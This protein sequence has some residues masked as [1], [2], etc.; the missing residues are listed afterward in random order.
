MLQFLQKPICFF[1]NLTTSNLKLKANTSIGNYKIALFVFI[2]ILFIQANFAQTNGDFRS[3]IVAGD[4]QS[5]GSW[6]TYNG[7]SWVAATSYPGQNAGAYE[8][9][10]LT[11]HTIYIRTD[12]TSSTMGDVI[13]NGR[14]NVGWTRNLQITLNTP[15]LYLNGGDLGFLHQKTELYLPTNSVI[16]IDNGGDI[17]GR[18]SNNTEIYIGGELTAVCRGGGSTVLTF[19]EVVAGGGTINSIITSPATSPYV[20]CGGQDINLL[21][22][23]GGA[24]TNVSYEW[25][26]TD[27]SSVDV[28]ISNS[29][30]TLANNTATT[31]ATSFTPATNGNYLVSLS[32]TDGNFTNIESKT[33]TISAGTAP[34]ITSTSPGSVTGTGTAILGATASAGT[35]N[36]YA[37]LTGGSSLGTGTSFT[38]PTISSTTTYYVD[39]TSGGCTSSPRIAIVATGYCASNGNSTNDEYIGRVQLN[40]IDNSSGVGTTST[41]YSDFTSISTDLTIGSIYSITITPTWTGSR[42]REGYNVW[43]DYNNDGDFTDSGENVYTQSRTNALS[44]SG[45]FSI[46]GSAVVGNT[47]MRVSMKY[48]A[49]STS[50]ESFGYGEVEDYTINIQTSAPQPEI[51][52]VGNGNDILDGDATPS[53]T[54]DT[55]FGTALVTSGSV[56]HTFTIQ[57]TGAVDLTLDNPSPYVVIAGDTS[58]FTLTS[59]PTTPIASSGSTTFTITFDPTS[60]GTKNATISIANNDSNENPYNFSITGQGTVPV[61]SNTVITLPYTQDFESGTNGWNTGGSDAE[62]V[63]NTTWSYSNNYS[64]QIRDN[65]GES[66]SFCSPVMSLNAYDKVDFKFFFSAYSME[67]NEDFFIEYSSD[68]GSTWTIIDTFKSGQVADKE[69]DFENTTLTIFY[70]KTSTIFKTDHTFPVATEARFRVRC[71]ASDDNDIIFIDDISIKGTT[72]ANPTNGPG[73]V[74]SDLDL[75]LKADKV[76]GTSVAADGSNLSKWVDNGKGNDAEVV[77][78]GQEPTY[79]NSTARNINF[80]PVVDFENDNTTASSDMTYLTSRDELKGTGGFNSNDMFVVIIPDPTITNSM[81]P[82]DTFTSKDPTGETYQEDVTGFGYGSFTQRL[83]GEYFTYC[84]GTSQE[85]PPSSGTYTGFGRGDAS[86]SNNYNQISIINVRHNSSNDNMELYLNANQVGTSTND[87]GDFATITNTRYWL[88]RSQY[89]NGSFDGRIAE[90]ITYSSTKS[91]GNLTQDRNRIQSYLGIKYG[92][93]LG[94][95]GTSQDY[96]DSDGSVIWDQSVNDGYNFDVAGIGRDDASELNQK[97]SKSV[98]DA[99]DG[100]GPTQGVLTMGLTDIYDTNSENISINSANNLGNKQ[101]L[102]WGNNGIDLNFATSTIDVNM[103][104]GISPALSTDVHFTGMQR[105]WKVVEN[106]GDIPKVKIGLRKDAVRNITPPG[107]YLMFISDNGVFTPTSDYRI[108]TES[109][110]NLYTEYDFDGT[111]YITFGYAPETVVERSIYFNGSADYIDMEDALDLSG[112]E[113]TISSWIK[114][115]SGSLNKSILSK[116]NVGYSE[117]YDF[118]INNSGKVEMSW[119]NSGAQ[120]ITSNTSIPENT[121]HQVAVIYNSGIAK[122]YID[123]VLDKTVSSLSNPSATTQSFFIAAAGKNAPEAFFKGNIDE[124]RIWDVALSENQ[125]RYIMNQEIVDN[126]N[127]TNGTVI[128]NTITKNEIEIIPYSNLKGY[129]PMSVYTYTNTNDMSGNLNQGALRNLNTVDRQT[130]P[131]PYKSQSN[132]SWNSAGTWLNNSVQSLPNSLSIVDGTTSIDWNIVETNHD[133]TIDTYS[134][135]GREVKVLG[136]MVNSNKIQVNGSTSAV[137]GNG[138]NVS[139][140]LKLDGTIDLEGESQ[141]IQTT[142]SDLVVGASGRLERDQQGEGNKYRY[143]DWS[144]PVSSTAV[145]STFKVVDVLKD[146][147]N[148]GVDINF[149]GGYDGNNATNPIQIANFWIYAFR[150]RL[151]DDYSQWEQVGSTTNLKAGEGFLMKGTGS[152]SDQNYVFKGVPNNGDITLSITGD[153]DYLVGNPYPSALDADQFL[154][155]NAGNIEGTLYFWE[156]YGGD[157]HNLKG[158]QAGYASYNFSGSVA[159]PHPITDLTAGPG[160][161]LPGRFIPIGQGFTIQGLG[162]GSKNV[163]FNNGQRAFQKEDVTNSIFMRTGRIKKKKSVTEVSAD[164]RPKF[165]IGFDV[166]GRGHRELLL[167]I[168]ERATE[169]I[170]WGFDGAVYDMLNDDMYWVIEDEKHVIQGTNNW[171]KSMEVPFGIVTE[172][173]GSFSIKIDRLENV[174][175]NTSLYIKDLLT[176]ETYDIT[177]NPFEVDLEAGE[178]NDRYALTFQPRLKTLE[179]IELFRGFN[180]FMDNKRSE[181]HV[182]KIVDTNLLEIELYNILG[183]NVARFKDKYTDRNLVLPLSVNTGVYIVKIMTSNGLISKKIIIE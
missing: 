58:E 104:S 129:Y 182:N 78:S 139:H 110:G 59:N 171:S 32:V 33:I 137:T 138:L 68:D 21:G 140:Y 80:N 183:Q 8:V 90:I 141:L 63:N 99:S 74:I 13:V 101:F 15:L 130:A 81:L 76:D 29:T 143:N 69:C 124:V 145:N 103:S 142:G 85:S 114:R 38:T 27:P 41:G 4:W 9:T 10:I 18:C 52:I 72:Y 95:N 28:A 156:H 87:S 122:L 79:R 30:G 150:N 177:N 61:C 161:K 146:G 172:E 37:N 173:G 39:A 11:G 121:W 16:Q 23:F 19:G 125:L 116:R 179:E 181:L 82:L 26:V 88:G 93:T 180:I 91:S 71:D 3:A 73:G 123:G 97:Q 89:W 113:F 128:P 152:P 158:Y 98:N 62:R 70:S 86:G 51:N 31:T 126:S 147:T 159:V 24:V 151:N 115:V 48:D 119:G 66:S 55:D 127:F 92:I 133:I 160:T 131:L 1:Y 83:S 7:T 107:S 25:T 178:Y 49:N 176:G 53:S 111:K 162:V 47:R 175:E 117:G 77:T 112:S 109:N 96:V 12:F 166:K 43:I 165:R 155:D 100:S 40:T 67:D 149:V 105:V 157:T 164:L 108:M 46:P 35:I 36:W 174:D 56:A 20:S 106:G 163:V 144:S 57:N 65:S 132:G 45:S 134:N 44:V 154:I 118:K 120:N 34:T 5:N 168:D 135:F 136:L 60:A 64:L 54:D 22:M 42:Y 6:Q 170:D 102:V 148:G 17:I 153:N 167:T 84:I 14:L 2:N 75:W 94:T 50:C 169:A